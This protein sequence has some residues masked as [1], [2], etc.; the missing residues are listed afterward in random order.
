[1][2]GTISAYN[3]PLPIT[4][5]KIGDKRGLDV[6]IIGGPGGGSEASASV[7]SGGY[8]TASG[9]FTAT[10]TVGTKNVVIS[11]LP[12]SLSLC[13]VVGGGSTV[14]S[15]AGDVTALPSTNIAISGATITFADKA[16][17]FAA[18]DTVCMT[19]DGPDKAYDLS[20]D[21]DRVAEVNPLS[22]HFVNESFTLTNVPNATPDETI[23]ID[24]NGFIGCSVH[25][26]KTGGADTFAWAMESSVEG[27]LSSVD[28]IDSTQFGW[29]SATVVNAASYT[30]DGIIYTNTG[31]TPQSHKV[32]ITTAG[33][34]DD[35]DFTVTV[36][37]FY[38]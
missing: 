19:L 1:M 11:G 14:V 31:F 6:N 18:G 36:K 28:F 21:S 3:L 22:Q 7:G 9:D 32:V 29:T 24:M 38:S 17:N 15:A 23:I 26:E 16:V 10:P 37:K 34:A 33:A 4:G 35:A 30:V 5:T 20:A 12:F 13:T 27:T 2:P 25:V 8:T